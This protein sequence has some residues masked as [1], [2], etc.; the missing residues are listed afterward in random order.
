[1]RIYRRTEFLKLPEG[2]IYAKGKPWAFHNLSIKGY[3]LGDDWTYLDPI[4]IDGADSGDECDKLDAMLKHG[5]SHP[6]ARMYGRDGYF[7]TD[8]IFLVCERADLET[9]RKMIDDALAVADGVG[10]YNPTPSVL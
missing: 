2:T 10:P 9:L 6:M 3:S 4:G 1:M 7:D 8:A 5:E